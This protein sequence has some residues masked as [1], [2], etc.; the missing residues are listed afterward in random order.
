QE[1]GGIFMADGY[2]KVSGKFAVATT[3]QGPGTANAISGLMFAKADQTPILYIT[4]TAPDVRF[5]K[6]ATQETT[7]FGVN[8]YN[9]V[10][11]VSV[12]QSDITSK[13]VFLHH[14]LRA[15]NYLHYGTNKGPVHL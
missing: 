7:S 9:M 6:G 15:K 13:D 12:Y 2:A 4:G 3:I 1:S 5:G 8:L 10:K 14:L 11:E